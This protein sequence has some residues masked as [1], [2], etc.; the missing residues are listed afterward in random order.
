M[1]MDNGVHIDF[2][3]ALNNPDDMKSV[4]K[5]NDLVDNQNT[6]FFEMLDELNESLMITNAEPLIVTAA[7]KGKYLLAAKLRMLRCN[8]H[9]DKNGNLPFDCLSKEQQENVSRCYRML[10]DEIDKKNRCKFKKIVNKNGS[11]QIVIEKLF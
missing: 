7:R 2:Q 11:I 5:V 6:K 10:S 3:D 9:K 8:M 4:K 1:D